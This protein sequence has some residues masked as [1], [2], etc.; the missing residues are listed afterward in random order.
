VAIDGAEV[1]VTGDMTHAGMSPEIERAEEVEPGVYRAE[2]FKFSMAGDWFITAE[3]ELPD[4][5][6]VTRTLPVTV[7]R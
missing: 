7:P 6:K 2:G 1:E 4:G 3:I 5:N